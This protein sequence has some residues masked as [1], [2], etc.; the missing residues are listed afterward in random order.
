MALS[1]SLLLSA[2]M[3]P[4]YA[5]ELLA[6]HN[7]GLSWGQDRLS[8]YAPATTISASEPR[9]SRREAIRL[10]YGFTPTLSIGFRFVSNTDYED[11]RQ[12]MLSAT[13]LLLEHAEAAVLLL[14]GE[15][16]VLQWLNKQ[17]VINSDQREDGSW[18]GSRITIPFELRPLPSP[19]L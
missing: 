5:L 17:L 1:Y 10:G 19:L 13:L 3:S 16:T 12:T 11:F 8:L 4:R 18:L 15:T 2:N 6:T 7:H 14:N 9:E